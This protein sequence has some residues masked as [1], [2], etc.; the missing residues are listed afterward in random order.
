LITGGAGFIGANFVRHWLSAHPAHRLVV[1]DAFTYAGNADN[2]AGLD[3]A[4]CRVVRGD[5]LDQDLVESLLAEE[6]IDTVVHFA[7]ESHVDR[8]IEGPE[9]FI[10]TNVMGT[11]RLLEAVRNIWMQG[12]RPAG[13]RFHHV[14]T[15]EVYGSLGADEAPFTE[16][17]Q[18]APNSPY[19]ASKAASDHLVRAYHR[20]YDLPVTISHCSN[21]YGPLQFPE[22]LIALMITHVLR[23]RDLPVYG[24]GGNIRDWLYVEDHCRAIEAILERGTP[25]ET[26][27]IGARNERD[28][29][30]IVRTLCQRID[31]CFA[32]DPELRARFPAAPPAHGQ[33]SESLLRFVA[34]RPGHDRRYAVEPRRIAREL[35]FEPRVSFE[36]GL[37]NTVRWYMDNVRWWSRVEDGSYRHGV[38]VEPG[39]ARV[40]VKASAAG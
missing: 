33:A 36:V 9:A 17:S 20:T 23:G 28:N 6:R 3:P 19:A 25:G 26:Y 32:A 5:I 2:L 16:A 21:N 29:L 22:K 15:D 40:D 37:D 12:P 35:G 30:D 1:L 31:R 34:D 7:A 27:D 18:F 11:Q 24:D 13:A 38:P 4:A 14:S 8:S 10:S 39:P